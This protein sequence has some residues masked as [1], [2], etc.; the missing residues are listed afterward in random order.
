MI[1]LWNKYFILNASGW[2]SKKANNN[3]F[4]LSYN[5]GYIE[6][7]TN[8]LSLDNVWAKIK[9]SSCKLSKTTKLLT[10]NRQ[11]VYSLGWPSW[12]PGPRHVF[13]LPVSCVL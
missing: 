7:H 1:I 6:H 13:L 10:Y 5:F 11:V 8:A 9:N 3:L 12:H 2:W 4:F